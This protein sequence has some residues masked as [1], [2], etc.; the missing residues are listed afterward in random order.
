MLSCKTNRFV[1]SNDVMSPVASQKLT[2]TE[3]GDVIH[4][5]EIDISI[6]TFH[7]KPVQGEPVKFGI[8][9]LEAEAML[10]ADN[11]FLSIIPVWISPLTLVVA[12]MDIH[13]C[14]I[15][16]MVEQETQRRV[17]EDSVTET[18][19]GLNDESNEKGW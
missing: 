4:H 5:A 19:A 10:E 16:E 1:H 8:V 17:L 2:G 14:V 13:H 11:G 3:D 18:I 7:S 6:F 12:V 15:S 9:R